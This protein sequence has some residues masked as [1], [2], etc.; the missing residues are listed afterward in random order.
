MRAALLVLAAVTSATATAIPAAAAAAAARQTSEY[1]GYLISTF[2]DADPRVQWHL[3][4][5]NS[6]ASFSF[7]NGGSPVLG[8]T[9]GTTGVRDIYLTTNSARSEF[10]LIATGKCCFFSSFFSFYFKG[11]L[12]SIEKIPKK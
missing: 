10:Y 5:G 7:L 3:S 2:T 1:A 8:S 12:D 4:D 6:A 11:V 9:V